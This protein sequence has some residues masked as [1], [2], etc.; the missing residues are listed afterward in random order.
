[1]LL[2]AGRDETGLA[3]AVVSASQR[4]KTAEAKGQARNL[5]GAFDLPTLAACLGRLDAYLCN[6]S[7]PMH[8][9]WIQRVPVLALFGP[10]VPGQGFA[11]RGDQARVL[12]TSLPC[13]PCGL[14]GGR[15]CRRGDLACLTAITPEQVWSTLAPWLGAQAS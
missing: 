7:G 9:A 12:E 4:W 15:R 6:D 13:R 3:E 14:H 11:P 1:V 8:L 2:F 10:T 5:A